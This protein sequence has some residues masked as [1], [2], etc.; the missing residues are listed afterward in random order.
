MINLKTESSQKNDFDPYIMINSLSD[1]LAIQSRL[2]RPRLLTPKGQSPTNSCDP[3]CRRL[4]PDV[5][6]PR[7]VGIDFVV[8]G[9]VALSRRTKELPEFAIFD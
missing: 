9:M 3:H 8:L 5:G 6:H 7:Y 1:L 2:G 4:Q